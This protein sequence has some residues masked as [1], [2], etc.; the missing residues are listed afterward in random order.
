[1]PRW[2]DYLEPG[3]VPIVDRAEPEPDV[4]HALGVVFGAQVGWSPDR[5]A[6]EPGRC[7]EC[8]DS[9]RPGS[10]LVCAGCLA[11]GFDDQVEAL[12]AIA[13][14]KPRLRPCVAG[15]KKGG[16]RRE[17]VFERGPGG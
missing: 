1:M 2:R 4:P 14:P 16:G 11:S 9:I 12:L 15:K 5:E 7:G 17:S 3:D 6:Q 8:G 10:R 13:P